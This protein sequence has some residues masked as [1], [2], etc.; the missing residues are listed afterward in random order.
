M[1]T[2]FNLT[3][4][5]TTT[6]GEGGGDSAAFRYY[7]YRIAPDPTHLDFGTYLANRCRKVMAAKQEVA[8]RVDSDTYAKQL[9]RIARLA[10]PMKSLSARCPS[11]CLFESLQIESLVRP[12]LRR[13][14]QRRVALEA[15]T[16]PPRRRI[17]AR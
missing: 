8:S 1:I 11:E 7:R 3:Y 17:F 13:I 6:R 5:P 4:H 9:D 15:V 16:N 10:N 12:P 2:K 14:E